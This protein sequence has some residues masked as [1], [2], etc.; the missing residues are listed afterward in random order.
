MAFFSNHSFGRILRR[1]NTSAQLF[2]EI[3]NQN[4]GYPLNG[5]IIEEKLKRASKPKRSSKN[6]LRK[7]LKDSTR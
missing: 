6:K 5:F 4:D 2:L 7:N 1:R 3:G